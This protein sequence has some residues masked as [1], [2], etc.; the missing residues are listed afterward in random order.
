MDALYRVRVHMERIVLLRMVVFAD[1]LR[2]VF[3]SRR[4]AVRSDQRSMAVE[5]DVKLTAQA[6]SCWS[7]EW[8]RDKPENWAGDGDRR[9]VRGGARAGPIAAGGQRSLEHQGEGGRVET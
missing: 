5:S 3:A 4:P 1:R 9:L 7:M 6:R 8:R 2:W